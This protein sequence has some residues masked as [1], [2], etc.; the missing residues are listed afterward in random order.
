M[1]T[2][3]SGFKS[4][5]LITLA[6]VV[7]AVLTIVVGSLYY[8]DAPESDS[9]AYV[10]KGLLFGVCIAAYFMIFERLRSMW[11]IAAFIVACAAADLASLY[12][13]IGMRTLT[14]ADLQLD[15]GSP[16]LFAAGFAGAFIILA[17]GLFL[18]GRRGIHWRSLATTFLGA[19]GGGLLGI[20]GWKIGWLL[21]PA[22]L[23]SSV[24]ESTLFVLW[25]TGVAL[26]LG[27]LLRY[28]R[29]AAVEMQLG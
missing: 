10:Y 5:L 11:R 13:V 20:L 29:S 25:Q 22:V 19:A 26:M 9:V 14:S 6:G 7:S 1:K 2:Q 3:T 24:Q 4:I 21:S 27:L 8:Y 18:F 16:A 15:V 28:E 12:A 17:A 23:V